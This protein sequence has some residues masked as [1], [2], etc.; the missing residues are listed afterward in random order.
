ML[1]KDAVVL[2][3]TKHKLT[4]Y[5]LAKALNCAAAV[6]VNQWLRGTRMSYTIAEKFKTLYGIEIDDY[7]DTKATSNRDGRASSTVI[8]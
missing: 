2:I 3:L 8:E 6:S 7:Y 5:A 4:K 1:T